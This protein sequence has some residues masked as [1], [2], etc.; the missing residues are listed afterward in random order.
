MEVDTN[1]LDDNEVVRLKIH[2]KLYSQM[3]NDP[4]VETK[5][6]REFRRFLEDRLQIAE[7]ILECHAKGDIFYQERM[8]ESLIFRYYST[9]YPP[10]MS[11]DKNGEPRLAYRAQPQDEQPKWLMDIWKEV[12]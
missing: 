5:N 4:E 10:P 8:M 3:L 9:L 12:R 2:Q 6:G 1:T 7:G 11:F